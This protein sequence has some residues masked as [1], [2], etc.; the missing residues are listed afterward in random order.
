MAESQA[1]S[2]NE[3]AVQAKTKFNQL[4]LVYGSVTSNGSHVQALAQCYEAKTR[5]EVFGIMARYGLIG[6]A[7]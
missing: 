6:G 4:P 7:R 1:S 5:Q 3:P 2:K